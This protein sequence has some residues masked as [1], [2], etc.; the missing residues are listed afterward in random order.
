MEEHQF[1]WGGHPQ[2]PFVPYIH[3]NS[4]DLIKNNCT[5][6]KDFFKFNMSCMQ[7]FQMILLNSLQAMLNLPPVRVYVTIELAYD[8]LNEIRG[9]GAKP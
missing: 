5:T 9:K 3:D 6:P 4:F 7:A 2:I 8:K 1:I